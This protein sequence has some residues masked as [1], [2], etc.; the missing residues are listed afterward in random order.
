MFLDYI[1]KVNFTILFEVKFPLFPSIF[2]LL[3]YFISIQ[4]SKEM[5]FSAFVTQYYPFED[6]LEQF[7]VET[8]PMAIIWTLIESMIIITITT[9]T[10]I[11]VTNL[12]TIL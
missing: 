10:A 12:L 9:T 6:L 4:L 2:F 11:V 3:I 5:E 7:F 8:W 1:Y